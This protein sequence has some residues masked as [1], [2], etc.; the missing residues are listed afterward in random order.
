MPQVSVASCGWRVG[1]GGSWGRSRNP[2]C[3]TLLW[4]TANF[5][6]N[7]TACVACGRYEL[8]RSSARIPELMLED[9]F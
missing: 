5:R 4:D 2:F 3:Q 7:T 6:R 8:V 1:G 9:R